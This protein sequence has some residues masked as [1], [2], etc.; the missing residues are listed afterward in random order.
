[1]LEA[2]V[3]PERLIYDFDGKNHQRPTLHANGR[4]RAAKANIVIVG[5]V[6]VKDEFALFHLEDGSRAVH[7]IFGVPGHV[8]VNAANVNFVGHAAAEIALELVKIA[9][10]LIAQINVV[11]E[12]KTELASVKVVLLDFVVAQPFAEEIMGKE[13]FVVLRQ[14]NL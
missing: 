1:M 14:Q 9:K 6:N 11:F 5:D 4:A 8:V 13:A 12:R 3:L 10:G 2:K 7:P